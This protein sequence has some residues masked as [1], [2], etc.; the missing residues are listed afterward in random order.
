MLLIEKI[1]GPKACDGW[2]TALEWGI[3]DTIGGRP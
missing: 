3:A 1:Q 2:R